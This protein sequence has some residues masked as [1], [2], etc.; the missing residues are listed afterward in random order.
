MRRLSFAAIALAALTV[1]QSASAQLADFS[2]ERTGALCGIGLASPVCFDGSWF[3]SRTWNGSGYVHTAGLSGTWSG[4]PSA[5]EARLFVPALSPSDGSETAI[6][7]DLVS[8]NGP[9]EWSIEFVAGSPYGE[10]ARLGGLDVND[11]GSFYRCGYGPFA[12]CEFTP[13][14]AVPEPGTVALLATGLIGM[15]GVALRRRIAA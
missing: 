8:S 6:G 15:F 9:Q 3:L 12:D 5:W 13:A 4:L 10:S 7:A 14:V 11:G 2:W 1:P